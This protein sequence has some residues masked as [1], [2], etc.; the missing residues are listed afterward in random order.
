MTAFLS[1]VFLILIESVRTKRPRAE[2]NL[3]SVHVW[4]DVTFSFPINL[5][6]FWVK[7]ETIFFFC[8]YF[9]IHRMVYLSVKGLLRYSLQINII[10]FTYGYDPEFLM[11]SSMLQQMEEASRQ[12]E[13]L[14]MSL[15][16]WVV[17]II[18]YFVPLIELLYGRYRLKKTKSCFAKSRF[19]MISLVRSIGV[20]WQG[21]N[22][23]VWKH[24]I[25][26]SWWGKFI[27][28]TPQ[29]NK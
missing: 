16:L 24:L 10:E 14:Y 5:T 29:N 3:G 13:H 18:R 21:M 4:L 23:P 1:D 12:Q 20:H 17:E 19:C 8:Y 27:T 22:Y 26:E 9:H 7:I 6:N 15:N 11:F 25:W 28:V 2:I